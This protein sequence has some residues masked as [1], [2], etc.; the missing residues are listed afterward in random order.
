MVT[1]WIWAVGLAGLVACEPPPLEMSW[2]PI[3]DL[4]DRL[5]AGVQVF[6]G[7]A[8]TY[9]LRAWYVRIAKD[10]DAT[11][12]VLQSDDTTDNRETVASFAADA[13]ACV[14]VNGGY[15]TM[16]Q[17]PARHAGLLVHEGRVLAPATQTVTRDSVTYAAVRAA[18]GV[19]DSGTVEV[20]WATSAHDSVFAWPRA[21]DHHPGVPDRVPGRENAAPWRVREAV[22]AG[23]RLVRDGRPMVAT[24]QEVFFGSSIPDVHPRTAAGVTAHG[25]LILLVVDGRQPQSRGV[26]LQEL[27][28]L[29][30]D[31]GVRDGLNLDGGGS[32][33][34]IVRG[35]LL[36]RPAGG[37][38]LR[39]VMSAIVV[40][41][42]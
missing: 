23:P 9:P 21:P 42:P 30:T 40:Q 38:T 34:L 19:T 31:L 24:N 32:S 18:L 20:V 37:T 15:F 27:A 4:N 13:G 33:S 29:M 35:R 8:P 11:I 36:N 39:E 41:C 14:A 17:T 5:P 10:A 3:D 1:R 7:L 12:R 2:T 28:G 22:G 26:N 25:D 6:E 16:A